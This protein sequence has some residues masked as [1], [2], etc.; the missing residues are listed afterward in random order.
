VHDD[1]GVSH[2]PAGDLTHFLPDMRTPTPKFCKTQQAWGRFNDAAAQVDLSREPFRYDL[3]NI[4]REC[5][6]Q[7]TAPASV[8]FSNAIEQPVLDA[9]LI[10]QT[11]AVYQSMLSDLELLLETNSEFQVCVA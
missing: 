8:N 10:A 5:I 9:D 1:T 3:V 2:F 11:G 4:A 6:A 7:L